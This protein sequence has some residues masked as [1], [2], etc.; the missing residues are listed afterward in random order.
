LDGASDDV[1]KF[2]G[3]PEGWNCE[4]HLLSFAF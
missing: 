1:W 4:E 3:S 2:S